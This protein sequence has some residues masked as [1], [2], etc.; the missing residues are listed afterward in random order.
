MIQRSEDGV[1]PDPRYEANDENKHDVH[2]VSPTCNDRHKDWRSVVQLWLP[3][4]IHQPAAAIKAA[5][6]EV[7]GWQM[8]Q[9]VK[10]PATPP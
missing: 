7:L 4:K 9:I 1:E 5:N 2:V 6:Q 8:N 3:T 10:R